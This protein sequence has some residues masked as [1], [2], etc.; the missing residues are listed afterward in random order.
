VKQAPGWK[1]EQA[2][3]GVMIWTTP[4]GRTYTTTGPTVYE[5]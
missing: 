4:S 2:E 1:L 3:P 5:I